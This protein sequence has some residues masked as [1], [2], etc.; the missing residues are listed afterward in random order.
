MNH[1]S[2]MILSKRTHSG[3]RMI[4]HCSNEPARSRIGEVYSKGNDAVMLIG[5]EGDFSER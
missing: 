1:V 2:L 4:A 3:S 5:P